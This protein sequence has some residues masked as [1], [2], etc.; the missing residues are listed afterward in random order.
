MIRSI[1]NMCPVVFRFSTLVCLLLVIAGC[2]SSGK[3][4]AERAGRRRHPQFSQTR[5]AAL[6]RR[7]TLAQVKALFGEPDAIRI[8]TFGSKTPKSWTVMLYKYR[9]GEHRD[10]GDVFRDNWLDFVKHEDTWRLFHFDIKTVFDDEA[11]PQYGELPHGFDV[12]LRDEELDANEAASFLLEQ[13]RL[14]RNKPKSDAAWEKVTMA[15]DFCEK[16]DYETAVKLLLEALAITDT[17]EENDL[18]G[19][20]EWCLLLMHPTLAMAYEKLGQYFL[21]DL[22]VGCRLVSQLVEI[23]RSQESVPKQTLEDRKGQ[24]GV[25]RQLFL[26]HARLLDKMDRGEEAREAKRQA[27]AIR[28]QY[29]LEDNQLEEETPPQETKQR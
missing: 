16:E 9:M 19:T 24:M 5:V 28:V 12:D 8:R 15:L 29:G 4:R 10:S 1:T 2:S 11:V 21:A 6:D 25:L 14:K 23:K 20:K 13:E 18:I 3:S 27:D 26:W 7:L 22:Y 17:M